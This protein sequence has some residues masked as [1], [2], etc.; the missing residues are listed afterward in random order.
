[1]P[2]SDGLDER[3][4][5]GKPEVMPWEESPASRF[6]WITGEP[7]GSF[8]SKTLLAHRRLLVKKQGEGNYFSDLIA[9]IDELLHERMGE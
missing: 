5:F 6:P 7:L 3:P 2:R 9:A 4:D 1:V 8:P